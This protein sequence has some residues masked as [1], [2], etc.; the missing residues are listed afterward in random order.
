MFQ[1]TSVMLDIPLHKGDGG[2]EKETRKE[3]NTISRAEAVASS[4]VIS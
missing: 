2:Q 1:A 3:W 4:D